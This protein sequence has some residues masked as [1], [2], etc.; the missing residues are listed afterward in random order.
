MIVLLVHV[1]QRKL[2]HGPW[3]IKAYVKKFGIVCYNKI[4]AQKNGCI[5]INQLGESICVTKGVEPP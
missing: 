5:R 2:W 4:E 1:S 3:G